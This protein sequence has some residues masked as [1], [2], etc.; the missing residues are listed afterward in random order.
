LE[1]NG[2]GFEENEGVSGR[3]IGHW[4]KMAFGGLF[5]FKI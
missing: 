5:F 1:G 2:R 4:E 3:N